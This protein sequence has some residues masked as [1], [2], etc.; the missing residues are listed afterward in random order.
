[1]KTYFFL[2]KNLYEPKSKHDHLRGPKSIFIFMPTSIYKKR[3]MNE[4]V[5]P[6]NQHYNKTALII[7]KC[8][9]FNLW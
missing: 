2:K 3:A 8:G 9:N 7:T 4:S 5:Q 6:S 1:M